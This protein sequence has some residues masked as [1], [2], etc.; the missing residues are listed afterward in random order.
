M[1]PVLLVETPRSKRPARLLCRGLLA[2]GMQTDHPTTRSEW[3]SAQTI[4]DI[5]E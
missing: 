1:V 4:V 2:V 5:E 3:P